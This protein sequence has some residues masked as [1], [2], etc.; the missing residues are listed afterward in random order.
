MS[1]HTKPLAQWLAWSR[2][3]VPGAITFGETGA[4]EDTPCPPPP[5]P[6][7]SPISRMVVQWT[8]RGLWVRLLL[9]GRARATHRGEGVVQVV[10]GP[11]DDD[12]VVDVQPE[13]QHGGGKAHTCGRTQHR[14][15][16]TGE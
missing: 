11:G 8:E 3:L 9:E 4:A 16:S 6:R 10:D 7:N 2:R 5:N 12:N 1:A 15:C 14:T 13:G